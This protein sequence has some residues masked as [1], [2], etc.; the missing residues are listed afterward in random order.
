MQEKVE[1]VGLH[2]VM[3]GGKRH[4]MWCGNPIEEGTPEYEK[5]LKEHNKAEAKKILAQSKVEEIVPDV[6]F[7]PDGQ[8]Y[9]KCPIQA[10][11]TEAHNEQ[12]ANQP[13]KPSKT[14]LFNRFKG[15]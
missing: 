6:D 3:I 8:T 11:V 14:G 4:L 10:R 7:L 1:G 5:I 2:T 15:R 13:V 9:G 12:F